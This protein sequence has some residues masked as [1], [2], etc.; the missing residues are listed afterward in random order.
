[1]QQIWNHLGLRWL[2]QRVAYSAQ[3]RSGWLRRQMPSRAWNDRPFSKLLID[4]PLARPET[5]LV[6]RKHQAP[7][8]FFQPDQIDLFRP[9]FAAWD[10]TGA[11]PHH[12][13]DNIAKGT[14]YYFAHTPGHVGFPPAWHTNPFNGDSTPADRH[15]STISDFG[16]SDIKL[17]WEPSR[18][19]FVFAL[20]R[21]YWR[22]GDNRYA[23]LFWQ[24]VED[25]RSHN[26]PQQGANW[27]CGQE[28][29][30][31][32]IAWCFGLYGVLTAPATTP[33][34]VANLA[35][36]IA[37]SGE[38]IASNLGYALSQ[39]NNHGISEGAGLWTI[40]VLFPELR[41]ARRWRERGRAVLE[42][43]A[44]E[45]IYDDGAF[46]QHSVNYHRLMLQDYLWAI[47]VGDSTGHPLSYT[48]RD[49]VRRAASWLYQV[50]DHISD[51]TPCYGHNDG[52]L[53][54]PLNNCDYTDYRPVV[55][56]VH[57][58][59]TG[60]RCY[61][62]GPWDEDLLWLFGPKAL[63]APIVRPRRVDLRADSGG[64][65]TL[66]DAESFAFVRCAAFRDRPSHADLLHVDLWWRGENIALDAGT[67]SYNAPAPWS[68]TLAETGYHNTVT[69]DELNQM[70][71]PATFLW[72]PW[73]HGR[74]GFDQ[75]D[76]GGSLA[77]WEGQHDGYQRLRAPVTHRRGILRLGNGWW[78]VL[79]RLLSEV[80]HTYR[81]HWLLADTPYTWDELHRQLTLNT[82][83]G[84]YVV[85]LGGPSGATAT[86]VRADV[87]SPRGWRSPYYYDRQPAISLDLT[88]QVSTAT[89]WTLFGPD[90][91]AIAAN[92]QGLRITT[93]G[94]RAEIRLNPN[95]GGQPLIAGIA[96]YGGHHDR[97][98]IA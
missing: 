56:A 48:L 53:V 55:Q 76:H 81:L 68:N 96:R 93:P 62:E 87:R 64:Y 18:F 8:F 77:Y 40:G 74:V 84:R 34:R 90:P 4:P 44:N 39:R 58:L 51:G 31:R 9:R 17:I 73:A 95:G 15:W 63:A 59:C 65:Y 21:A 6:Y 37:V 69:V 25:W 57:F 60:T 36:M 35:Q 20:V 78:L 11:L 54:L 79:D 83:A 43:Q 32:V 41:A 70:E 82:T 1:M 13:V 97:L 22:S 28:T 45:L 52:A 7:Q 42:S 66:R 33:E 80:M 2:A 85:K 47:R 92:F 46:S 86:L 98:E 94:W 27:K 19:G 67:Y 38:R 29:S 89:F 72:L 10:N 50:Q 14:L 24:L 71:R 26:P 5:Y 30:L 49:R 3:V 88:S 16:R 75:R 12:Q 23:E 91:A 61:S